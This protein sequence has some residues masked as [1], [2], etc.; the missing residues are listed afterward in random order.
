MRVDSF[1]FNITVWLRMGKATILF[2]GDPGAASNVTRLDPALIGKVIRDRAVPCLSPWWGGPMVLKNWDYRIEAK[3]TGAPSA[4]NL[5]RTGVWL[6]VHSDGYE[7][8]FA[9]NGPGE[10]TWVRNPALLSSLPPTCP[11][12]EARGQYQNLLIAPWWDPE[13]LGQAA[14]LMLEKAGP[15][16]DGGT[17]SVF[18]PTEGKRRTALH[19]AALEGS[20]EALPTGNRGRLRNPDPRDTT[21]ATPLLLAAAASHGGFALRLLELGADPDGCD[22]EGRTPLH[23][24][25]EGGHDEVVRSLL[26]AGAGV[27]PGDAYGTTPLHLAAGGGHLAA[28]ELLLRAGALPNSRDGIYSSTPLHLAARGNHPAMASLLPAAGAGIDASNEGGGLPCT[29]RPPT[30]TR[31]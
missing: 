18:A 19:R 15:P 2:P 17:S 25:A 7:T 6:R 22:R 27:S 11:P 14:L 3:M 28:A 5:E 23:R 29:W 31:R 16:L 21:G 30:A 1:D 9:M 4:A 13:M 8:R 24:A 26:A 20:L 10:E 12:E